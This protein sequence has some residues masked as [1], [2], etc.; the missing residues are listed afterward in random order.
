MNESIVEDAAL[1]GFGDL[2]YAAGH[3]PPHSEEGDQSSW[4]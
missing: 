4:R 3:V 1:E 2:C